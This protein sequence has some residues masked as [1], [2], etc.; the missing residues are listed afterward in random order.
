M[1]AELNNTWDAERKDDIRQLVCF[2]AGDWHFGVNIR[3]VRRIMKSPE[4][5]YTDWTGAETGPT[6]DYL[7]SKIPVVDVASPGDNPSPP[8]DCLVIIGNAARMVALSAESVT[9]ILRI[10]GSDISNLSDDLTINY[11]RGIYVRDDEVVN[12]TESE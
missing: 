6:A 2:K 1:P 11:C 12:I 4:I 7:G 8:A 10:G 5:S 9:Q 3:Q